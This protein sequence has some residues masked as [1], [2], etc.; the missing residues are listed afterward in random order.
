MFVNADSHQNPGGL[1]P[2]QNAKLPSPVKSSTLRKETSQTD[3]DHCDTEERFDVSWIK[4]LSPKLSTPK[5]KTNAESKPAFVKSIPRLELPRFSGDP[6]E[7]P[8]FISLFKCLV[9]DQPL[10]DTQRMTYLQR[11]LV[12][13]AKKAIGGMLNHGH[14]YKAALTELEEQFGNEEIVAGA[15]MKT[16]LDH[17]IVIEGDTIQLRSFCN[18]LHNAVATMKSLGYS[19][20]LASSTNAHSALQKLPD[21]LKEK[22]GE[23]KVKMHPTIP[24]L[25]D[26]DE[27]LR[28]RLRAKTLVSEPLPSL[29]K[30]PKN[31]RTGNRRPPQRDQRVQNRQ[32]QPYLFSTLATGATTGNQSSP[33]AKTCMVCDKKHTIEKCDKFLAMDVNQRAQLGKEKKLCFCCFEST[34]HQ[35]RDC[36]RKKRCDMQGCNKYHHPLIHGAAPVF[37]GTPPLNSAAPVPPLNVAAPVFVATSSVNGVSSAVPLQVVPV[38]VVTSRGVKTNTFALLDSGSQTSLILEN[39]ADTIGLVGEDSPL[40]L[41]TIN[42]S[43]EPVRSR[44]VSFHV[45]A[46]EGTKPDAQIAVDEAWTVPQLNLPP[47]RVTRSMMQDFPHL[48][49]LSIPEVDSKYVTILL[50]ANVLEAIL[51]HDVRRGRPGQPVAILTAFGWTLAG[52]VNSVVKPERLH[53]MHVHR[54]L[55]DE[56]SLNKQVEDWWRT[57]SFGTKYEDASPR[58][59]EDNR[60]LEMLER[61]VKHVSDG[62]E[63]GMLWKEQDVKFPDNRPMAEKRLKSTERKLKR[64]EELARKYCAITDEYVDKGYARKL[65]P[66]EASVPTSKQWF[67]PHHPVRNPNKPDKV[68]IVMDAAAKHDG[69]SLNDKL[70]IGPDL[71][72]SL[73]G[74][75]L[76]FR[77]QRVG[78]AADIEAMFH[79][80]RVIEEDQPAL[81]FLWRNLELQRPPDVYQM[82]VAI[83]GAA[84][85]PCMANYVLRKTA[86]DNYGDTAFSTETIEAV[87]KNF[88]M[89]DFLKS[90]CDEATAVRM[91]HEMTSLLARGGFRLTKWI[92]S[93]REVL[94]Q[95]P[96]QEKASPS[97]DLKFD[98]LPIE[99]TLGL[100]WNTETDCFRFSVCSRQTPESTKRG[101][102]SRISTVFDP[103]GVLAPYMLPA[104]CLIQSLW[105]KSK[106]W[107]EPLDEED[108]STWNDWLGDLT[109]LSEFELPR[110]FCVNACPEASIQLHVFADA[111][112][113]GF[114]AVCYARYSLAD[115]TIKVLFVMAR[116]RVAPLKQISIPRLELQAAVLAV[117]LCCLIKRELSVTTEDTIFWS[118][119]KTVLQYIANESRRF[120]TFVANR[121]SEI[122]DVTNPTQWRHVSGHSN[123]A[124][125]CSRG[126]RVADLD[127]HCRWFN[128]P[129]FL[130]KPEEHGPQSTFIGPLCGNDKEVKNTKWSGHASVNDPRAYFPDPDKFS[131]WSRFRRVVAWMCRFPQNCRRRKEDRVLSPLT[132][133]ELHN[134]EIIAVRRSQV[135]SFHSDFEAL[136]SN[137]RLPVKSRLSAL[138]PYV[139][140]VGCLRVGGRLRKAPLPED[141][142]HPLILD[143]K[144]EI[145]HLI[146][147]H[148]HLRLYCTSNK[149]VLNELRQKYW[150]L[151]GL[152]TVQKF[153]SSCPSCRRLR[154]KPEPPV[155]ADLPDSRLGYQQPPFANTGV[156]YFGPMLVR[157]GRKTEKRYGVL[158]TCLTTRAVH[159]EIAHSLDTDSCLMAIRRMIAR[160]GKPAHIWSD[161]G[162]NFIGAENELREAIKRL[163][164]ERIGDQLSDDGVQWHFNPPSSPH[165]GGSWERLVQ[166]AKRALK[167]V[168]GK[169]CVNDETLLTF[170]AEVESLMNGRPLT[171]V[172][173][174]Y[175]DEE[176]LT[177]NHFLLGRRNPNLPPDVVSDKDLCSR[178]TWK[179]AQVMTQHFWKRWLR[180][181]VPALTERRKWRNEARNVR[182]G[183]L[184]LVVDEKSPRGCWP[185]ARVLRVFPGDD[186]RVRAAEVR[187]RSGVY[188][189]PAVKLCL[190]ESAK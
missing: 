166:S 64:D 184:V 171:H 75:L 137:K 156:D 47:Q 55:N 178:R 146:V 113:M 26:L 33:A 4:E 95:I 7:W 51:Q 36:T 165:F 81:R 155:M 118:D 115:G 148:H 87:E 176:A 93:S 147:M 133:A 86:L 82:L 48:K 119:S 180:E 67:L 188:T 136:K 23:K 100:K 18:T 153:T 114:G 187:T 30:P 154:A 140:E 132:T 80:V 181:Y 175:R 45:G 164:S 150:I 46:V 97:V 50:G 101:V 73:V 109:K 40:Q 71:L 1:S 185:L 170:M 84:S 10:T 27:W 31:G 12:G 17:P 105:R 37:V 19:H 162:T 134:A 92:S 135:D 128:G 174:D 63:V 190:L 124:D 122:H 104:K 43:G 138:N 74:V 22:W 42:S 62:Y 29:G 49:D 38:S 152:A 143:P 53:V 56:E 127:Q 99:R 11:A 85:S 39:F 112:E 72:N 68:R 117:R 139:D 172:S 15:F 102:L 183:D 123:P 151:K 24:T 141:S 129:D 60:A 111:S 103:L 106:G 32:E 125:D 158:F 98:E 79:Q 25:V 9:H 6:L 145:T 121:V 110:C 34:D 52:A 44:K 160:R 41:G 96:L 163:D 13:N 131:S 66:E 89:D 189:R 35:S 107:D 8:Q 94:S 88:Y 182:E 179:H 14:L 76:R 159:L 108:Q 91:F 173:T 20:D 28:A 16:V 2:P 177:P 167:A 149:H 144:H 142:R 126:L 59:R 77:E 186:G 58:S 168:A 54:V 57:E 120:H 61:T 70:H 3:Q 169:Q 78:L 116:N 157:H 161:N 90:V 83:F 5:G 21:S 130:S 65:T 69:V